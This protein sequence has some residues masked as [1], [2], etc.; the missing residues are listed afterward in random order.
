MRIGRKDNIILLTKSV[1]VYF[2]EK[3]STVYETNYDDDDDDND[4]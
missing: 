1:K 4:R 2:N 3:K